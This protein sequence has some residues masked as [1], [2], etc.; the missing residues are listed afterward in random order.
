MLV[1]TTNY[2]LLVSQND[3]EKN[4]PGYSHA[5]VPVLISHDSH[6]YLFFSC[7]DGNS[8]S[9][10][11]AARLN[12]ECDNV[13]E[14]YK[15]PLLSPGE[16]G[17]FDDSGCM[18][19]SYVRKLDGTY[20]FYYIGWN[21][22]VT[23]PFRNSIGIA[24]LSFDLG[25]P[26]MSKIFSGPV[27]GRSIHEPHFVASND[28]QFIEGKYHMWYLSCTKWE[29]STE[30]ITHYYH[31]KHRISKDG[32]DWGN[33]GNVAVDYINGSEYA[34]SVPRVVEIDNKYQMFFSS[35][36]DAEY[37]Y[38]RIRSAIS[39]DL[40]YW[41]RCLNPVIKEGN[42]P[43]VDDRMACYPFVANVNGSYKCFYNGDDYGR[44][45]ILT[46]ELRKWNETREPICS[47]ALL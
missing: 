3:I 5:A 13:I 45:G 28:V 43:R 42:I 7:R 11:F 16:L 40:E 30:G 24:K 4:Y 8:R 17:G 14:Y 47:S 31:I 22:G 2:Q 33:R 26:M 6:N 46:I 32:I 21:L 39:T 19:T 15:N 23:V 41:E 29:R 18:G 44:T 20:Y 10:V 27:V 36:G 25:E 35:R 37:P 38:Y 34:I 9:H 1:T 12:S